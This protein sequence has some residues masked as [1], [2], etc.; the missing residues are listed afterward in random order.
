[1]QHIIQAINVQNRES[2]LN[3]SEIPQS[4][5]VHL[6]YIIFSI[7]NASFNYNR[8]VFGFFSEIDEPLD[9]NENMS[10]NIVINV[11][12]KKDVRFLLKLLLKKLFSF[13]VIYSISNTGYTRISIFPIYC[14]L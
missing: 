14:M 1:M 9:F 4:L 10:T 7:K 8:K 12:S 11:L 13:K 3:A 6:N 5:A 2:R